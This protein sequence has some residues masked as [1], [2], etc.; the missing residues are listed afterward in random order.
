MRRNNGL[1]II[2]SAQAALNAGASSSYLAEIT[3]RRVVASVA[4]LSAMLSA[5]TAAYVAATRPPTASDDP[6]EAVSR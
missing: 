5:F 1:I 4:L 2:L 3:S 6:Q